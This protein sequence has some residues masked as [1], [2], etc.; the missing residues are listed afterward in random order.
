MSARTPFWGAGGDDRHGRV[1]AVAT[2]DGTGA[3]A[4][5]PDAGPARA[6]ARGRRAEWCT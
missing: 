4:L 6:C 2:I 1:L 3:R 5:M